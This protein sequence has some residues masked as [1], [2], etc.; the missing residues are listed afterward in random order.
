MMAD[1]TFDLDEA[2]RVYLGGD[3]GSGA[4][5]IGMKD[6][7]LT[8]RYGASAEA[9]KPQLD[10][11]LQAV[12]ERTGN[13]FADDGH[14]IGSWVASELPVLSPVA[15]KKIEAHILYRIQH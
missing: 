7:R 9:I 3:P 1:S 8:A 12:E 2:M 5:Q 4:I 10:A 6:E 15:C 11:V 14:S 13:R